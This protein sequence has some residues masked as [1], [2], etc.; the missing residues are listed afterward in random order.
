MLIYKLIQMTV[1]QQDSDA[2]NGERITVD[3][4]YDNYSDKIKDPL[5]WNDDYKLDVLYSQT[6]AAT[7]VNKIDNHKLYLNKIDSCR[8]WHGH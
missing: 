1:R 7:P 3:L 5:S 8:D 2:P 6:L 4:Y